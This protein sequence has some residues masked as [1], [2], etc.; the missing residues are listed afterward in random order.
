MLR[1]GGGAVVR[2]GIRNVDGSVEL[3]VWISRV[4]DVN[5]FWSF[6]VSLARLWS[7]G[8]PAQRDLVSLDHAPVIQQLERSLLLENEN[9]VRVDP[10]TSSVC[11]ADRQQAGEGGSEDPDTHRRII[12]RRAEANARLWK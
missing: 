7:N 4:E 11:S 10:L 6:V 3:A 8:V 12:D 9:A 1:S 2:V 5:A